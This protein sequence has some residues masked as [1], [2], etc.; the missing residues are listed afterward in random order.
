MQSTPMPRT[1]LGDITNGLTSPTGPKKNT[2][3]WK[4]LARASNPR[5]AGPSQ[6]ISLKRAVVDIE[7]EPGSVRK[8]KA[9]TSQCVYGPELSVGDV[10]ESNAVK[11]S[12][13]VGYQPCREP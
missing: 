12:A 7:E 1:P 9:A 10:C 2:A 5:S 11:I 13:E 8:K 3:K 6:A 4:K